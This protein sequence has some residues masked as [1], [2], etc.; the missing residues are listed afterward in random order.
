MGSKNL[1]PIIFWEYFSS[2]AD[3][4]EKISAPPLDVRQ[5]QNFALAAMMMLLRHIKWTWARAIW[6]DANVDDNVDDD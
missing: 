2:G 5:L 4:I 6:D 3:S 1:K